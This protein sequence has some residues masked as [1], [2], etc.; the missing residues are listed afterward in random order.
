M[1]QF[2]IVGA[3]GGI[4]RALAQHI[5]DHHPHA[6]VTA[7][8]RDA[9]TLPLQHERLSL[10]TCDHSDAA[11]TRVC[12]NVSQRTGSVRAIYLC[13]GILHSATL[14]PEKRLEQFDQ[15]AFE[16]VMN[17]NAALPLRWLEQCLPLIKQSEQVCFAA[18][19]ARVG[20]IS[21]NKL[22]GWYSYR[23]SKAALNMLLQ[24]AAVECQRRAKQLKLLAFHPGTTNTALSEP[25]QANVPEGK[26]FSPA[27]VAERLYT[28]SMQLEADGTLSFLDWDAQAID[29]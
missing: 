15:Q 8:V 1:Q 9:A 24:T 28:L 5:L 10:E 4:G 2:I 12:D 23:A 19:S 25:F 29:W 20:S 21:D 3:N 11:I 14:A 17:V 26:L 18:I 22:G 27:F 13:T 6:Q 16:E 7:V